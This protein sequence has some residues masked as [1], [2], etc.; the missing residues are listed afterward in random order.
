[1]ACRK[2]YWKKKLVKA[3]KRKDYSDL[4]EWIK[5][6]KSQ[7]LLGDLK[8]WIN[9]NDTGTLEVYHSGYNKYY[10]KRLHFLCPAMIARGELATL[11]FNAG[12]GLQ[13]AKTKKSE[14]RNK[15]QFSRITQSWAMKKARD[16]KREFI[17]KI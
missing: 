10:P 17:W 1:M 7:Y 16:Q 5:A 4:N 11:D 12:V 15:Q 6:I 3:G 14:L 13:N 2:K 9:L 8:R